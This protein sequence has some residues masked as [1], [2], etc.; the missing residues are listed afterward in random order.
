MQTASVTKN[1]SALPTYLF[2]RVERKKLDEIRESLEDVAYVDWYGSTTGRYDVAVALKGSEPRQVYSAIKS[3]REID[4]IESTTS[5]TPFEGYTRKETEDEDAE[6]SMG[7]VFLRTTG[8]TDE[9]LASLKKVSAVSEVLV[10]PGEWDVVATVR[11]GS[12]EDVLRTSVE[13][14]GDID[15]VTASETAFVYQRKAAE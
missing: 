4:G 8:D 6:S 7:Q 3:I 11:G 1:A 15:G 12:Y 14:I 5:F 13:E 10:V 9:V 2:A